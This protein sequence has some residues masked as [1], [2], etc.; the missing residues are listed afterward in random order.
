MQ[1]FNTKRMRSQ[2]RVQSC[3]Q[4]RKAVGIVVL[5]SALVVHMPIDRLDDLTEAGNQARERFWQRFT[6]V[7]TA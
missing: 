5:G 4:A 6:L 2:F 7:G 3:T 1:G